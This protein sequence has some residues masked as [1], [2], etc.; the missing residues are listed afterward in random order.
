MGLFSSKKKESDT[1]MDMG[2]LPPLPEFPSMPEE[3][4]STDLPAYEPT[5]SDIKREVS[6][7]EEQMSSIPTREKKVN[8]TLVMHAPVQEE[9]PLFIKV[10]H[11]KE[12]MR[13]IDALKERIALA[14]RILQSIEELREQEAQKID[15][16]KTEIQTIKEK[17]MAI[18]QNLFEV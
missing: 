2:S 16:W 14:E 12:A 3:M 13:S 5:I 18:D 4:P 1:S 8:P 15:A 7:P 17:L 10:D 9:K 11:Y 6:R